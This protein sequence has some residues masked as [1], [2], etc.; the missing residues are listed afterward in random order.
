ML[1]ALGIP[2]PK[3]LLYAGLPVH[4]CQLKQSSISYHSDS[5]QERNEARLFEVVVGGEHGHG[6]HIVKVYVEL[7]VLSNTGEERGE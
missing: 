4:Y 1:P 3:R 6:F 7:E 5:F 2:E